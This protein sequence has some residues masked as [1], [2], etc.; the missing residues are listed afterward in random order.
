MVQYVTDMYSRR[1]Q[2]YVESTPPFSQDR[3]WELTESTP[4]VWSV[5]TAISL[6]ASGLNKV[7]WVTMWAV[8]TDTHGYTHLQSR[9]PQDQV[10]VASDK[11][12]LC[13]HSAMYTE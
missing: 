7:H 4:Q 13:G 1:L 5:Y 12:G 8:R 6:L 10:I 3:H 2:L 9:S 11:S